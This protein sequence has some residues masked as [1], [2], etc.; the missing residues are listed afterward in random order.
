[1][2]AFAK[3]AVARVCSPAP[4]SQTSTG[5]CK[6]PEFRFTRA[7]SRKESVQMPDVS[8]AKSWTALPL[9]KTT[10]S[11]L[12][13]PLARMSPTSMMWLP[14]HNSSSTQPEVRWPSSKT[15]WLSFSGLNGTETQSGM[16]MATFT[17][18]VPLRGVVELLEVSVRPMVNR[19]LVLRA[20]GAATAMSHRGVPATFRFGEP[21]LWSQKPRPCDSSVCWRAISEVCSRMTPLTVTSTPVGYGARNQTMTEGLGSASNSPL[22]SIPRLVSVVP[23]LKTSSRTGV[24]AGGAEEQPPPPGPHPV[25]NRVKVKRILLPRKVSPMDCSWGRRLRPGNALE[26]FAAKYTR[27]IIVCNLRPMLARAEGPDLLA[28]VARGNLRK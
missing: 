26:G 25:K 9:V 7:K 6:R 5:T 13:P 15:T 4:S 3:S 18:N 24:E 28:L 8:F 12:Q 19:S 23:G 21:L 1:M 22:E 2:S 11:S 10:I 20:G 27:V 14:R 17:V 16:P